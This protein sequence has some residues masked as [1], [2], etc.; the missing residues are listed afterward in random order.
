VLAAVG[1]V[2]VVG[3]GLAAVQA[4]RVH[5]RY[6]TWALRPGGHTP[7]IPFHGRD[8][9]RGARLQSLP[10]DVE[11]IGSAPG[12]GEV[13]SAP[14]LPGISPTVLYVRYPDGSVFDYAL[15]GGP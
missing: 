10:V 14:P 9:D 6:G 15:S 3:M 12:N 1:M 8:Y 13:F 11:K 5:H 7:A 4:E 2:L